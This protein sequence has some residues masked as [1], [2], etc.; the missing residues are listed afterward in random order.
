[1]PPRPE[2]SGSGTGSFRVSQYAQQRAG[3]CKAVFVAFWQTGVFVGAVHG[4]GCSS[5]S[6]GGR[7]Q[8]KPL[9][10]TVMYP[11]RNVGVGG[12]V[13]GQ[14]RQVVNIKAAIFGV[15]RCDSSVPVN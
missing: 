4:N 15:C 6:C 5:T 14:R 1:M 13:I 3:S 7:Q 12:A 9:R 2:G 8:R 11:K 10:F